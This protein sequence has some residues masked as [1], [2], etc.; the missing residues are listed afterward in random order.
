MKLT[1]KI[2]AAVLLLLTVL[3]LFQLPK[4]DIIS[5]YA[6]KY[7]ASGVHLTDRSPGDITNNDFQVPLIK[8]ADAE[9]KESSEKAR[10]AVFGLAD[11]YA[12]CRDGQG[13]VLVHED[14]G[15]RENWLVPRRDRRPHSLPYPFG[16]LT[17][18]DTVFPEIDYKI[19]EKAVEHAFSN[20]DKQRTRTLLILYK[21]RIIAER[22][23]DGIDKNTPVLGWS[24]TKSI[25]STLYGIM[26]EKGVL[27]I[28]DQA[29]IKE[30]QGDDR[31]QI[32][33]K[34]LL[35]MQSGLEWEEDYTKISD[36]TKMLFFDADMT[37]AQRDKEL[38]APPGTKWNYSSGTSNLLSGLLRNYF[39][40]DQEYLDFPYSALID[41]IGMHSMLIETDWEGNFVASSYAWATT[42]DWGKFG[43]LY[44]HRGEWNGERIFDPSWIDFISTPVPDSEGQ[45]G[46]HFWLNRGKTYPNAPADL[47]SANGYQ[48]QH[49]FIIPSHDMVIVRTGLAETP[50]FDADGF[51]NVLFKAF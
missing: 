12:I 38:Q 25:L 18:R 39:D 32:T 44:L 43:L 20:N 30:W 27:N 22:Y 19:V 33:L 31:S 11:R 7:M 46:G 2:L 41:R 16:T 29:D 50:E 3:I 28:E 15:E 37:Q 14:F 13:C 34:N 6:A 23:A 24:M 21:D 5:G 40:S 17:P 42:R 36:V 9:I 51:F 49:V 48:G 35:Q 8:Y 1:L 26:Q 4:L 45:Y 10:G 47:Y